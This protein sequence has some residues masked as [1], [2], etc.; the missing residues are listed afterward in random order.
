[1]SHPDTSWRI[2]AIYR[3]CKRYGMTRST[4]IGHLSI[5]FLRNGDTLR[6]ALYHAERLVEIWDG[7]NA[8][9]ETNP[10]WRKEQS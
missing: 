8:I 9:S 10:S 3:S 6:T 2:G 5:N 7:F 1:M 4:A